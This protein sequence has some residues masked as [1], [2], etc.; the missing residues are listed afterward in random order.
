MKD[1]T[2]TLTQL[3]MG[4]EIN[5]SVLKAV[6]IRLE[7]ILAEREKKYEHWQEFI[8]PKINSTR[9]K[10]IRRKHEKSITALKIVIYELTPYFDRDQ[11][12]PLLLNRKS[13]K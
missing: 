6:R 7:L 12:E 9:Q 13:K 8:A 2:R 10:E 11:D 4:R 5:N 3:L 1:S